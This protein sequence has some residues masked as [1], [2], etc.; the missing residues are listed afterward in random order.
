MTRALALRDIA[1]G[2]LTCGAGFAITLITKAAS[3]RG[4]YVVAVGSV[5][6][7]A[8][9]LLRGLLALSSSER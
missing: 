6:Y 1:I 7:G 8:F 5:L 2:A 4:V 9:R 3:A